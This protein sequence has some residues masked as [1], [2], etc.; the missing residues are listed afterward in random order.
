MVISDVRLCRYGG[1][2]RRHSRP[3]SRDFP[4]HSVI[5]LCGSRDETGLGH[6]E[7]SCF[8]TAET[9]MTSWPLPSNTMCFTYIRGRLVLKPGL[10]RWGPVFHEPR[11]RFTGRYPGWIVS[12]LHSLTT[13][14]PRVSNLRPC[15]LRARLAGLDRSRLL[16]RQGHDQSQGRHTLLLNPTRL[17]KVFHLLSV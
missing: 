9:P 2:T 14:S 17:A 7:L 4:H 3:G 12:T 8:P 10:A 15:T 1:G 5:Q 11:Q 13:P 6:T 16:N